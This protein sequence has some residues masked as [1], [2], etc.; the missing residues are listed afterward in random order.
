MNYNS[1]FASIFLSITLDRNK[2]DRNNSN[3][4]L[5]L[6]IAIRII[7]SEKEYYIV[8]FLFRLIISSKMELYRFSNLLLS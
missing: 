3:S 2:K 6:K 1:S 4:Y 8:I 7:K 5:L